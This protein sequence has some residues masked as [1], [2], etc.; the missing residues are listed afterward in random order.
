MRNLWWKGFILIRENASSHA[1]D[2]TAEYMKSIKMKEWKDWPPFNS[3]LNLIENVWGII[4][5]QLMK[6][7]INKH[8]E[9]IKM[10]KKRIR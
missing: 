2:K 5:T 1:S 7:E 9:L 8:P 6:K 10:I 3:D 4:K